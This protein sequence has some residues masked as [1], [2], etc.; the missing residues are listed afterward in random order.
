MRCDDP[1]RRANAVGCVLLIFGMS[2]KVHQTGSR[3]IARAQNTSDRPVRLAFVRT[4]VE[5]NSPSVLV[6]RSPLAFAIHT[7]LS[8]H[9]IRGKHFSSSKGLAIRSVLSRFRCSVFRASG[10]PFTPVALLAAPSHLAA[11]K[12]IL[13][14]SPS[15]NVKRPPNVLSG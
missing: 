6:E 9:L 14:S 12:S 10:Q 11:S 2:T 8:M 4:G 13:T 3:V 7:Y 5:P 1:H 15:R